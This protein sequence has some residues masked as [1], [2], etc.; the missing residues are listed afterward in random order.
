MRL[1]SKYSYVI[2]EPCP[3]DYCVQKI[4][5]TNADLC[6]RWDAYLQG[7]GY[8]HEVRS[9]PE[10][11][12]S[13]HVYQEIIR[14]ALHVPAARRRRRTSVTYTL[15]GNNRYGLQQHICGKVQQ[16]L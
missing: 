8:A 4:W 15:R 6:A 5:A 14:I 1:S 7:L 13:V 2:E 12:I 11:L 10:K 9:E 3:W 16:P